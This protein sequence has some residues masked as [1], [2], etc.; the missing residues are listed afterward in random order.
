MIVNL[1]K[2]EKMFSLCLPEKVKGK[3]WLEDCDKRGR[4]RRVISVEGAQ[5]EWVLKSNSLVSILDASGEGIFSARL[6]AMSFLNLKYLRGAESEEGEIAFLFSERVDES[7]SRFRKYILPASGQEMPFQIGREK[8]NHFFYNNRFVSGSHARLTYEGDGNWSIV[9]LNSTNGTYVNGS[10]IESCELRAGDSIYIMGLKLIVGYNFLAVNNPDNQ[11]TVV[12]ENL[13]EYCPQKVITSGEAAPEASGRE[14]FFRS[15]RFHREIAPRKITIDPP[16]QPQKP[17]TVPMALMLGP[18]MTMGFTSLSTGLLTVNN[19]LRSGGNIAQAMPSV[20]MSFSMLL[21]TVLWPVLTR[22]YERRQRAGSERRRQQKYLAYLD[23]LRDEIRRECKIQS[24]I[25]LENHVSP[26]ECA[27]RILGRSANLWERSAGQNDFLT[28]RLGL[29]RLPLK[30]EITC[31]EKKFTMEEDNLQDAMLALG[32]EPKSV[33][34]VPV[35]ISLTENPVVGIYGKSQDTAAMLKSIILQMAAL[36]SSDELKLMMIADAGDGRE[37]EF[38]RFLPHLWNEERTFRFYAAAVEEVRELSSC[39]EKVIRER[40]DSRTPILPGPWI[41]VVVTDKVLAEKCEALQKLLQGRGNCGIS[42]VIA[43]E[44]LREL[45]GESKLVIHAAGQK[46]RV[47]DRSG[48]AEGVLHFRADSMNNLS[49]PMLA[50]ALAGI[51]PDVSVQH[52]ALPEQI[53]FLELFQVGK[54]EHLNSLTRWK[55]NNPV[56]TLQTPVGV[57]AAGEPFFLDLHER[58]HGPHG[59]VAGMTG[60]GKSEFIITYILSLAVNYHPDEVAFILIDYKGGGL[61]GAFEDESKGVRL[62]HLAGTITNLDGAAVKRSLVSIQS[63]LRRRQ[64]IFNGAK[65][66]SNAGTMDIYRYQQ[67]YRQGVV[68]EPVPHLFIISDEFAELKKQQSEFMEQL[69]SAARIGRSLGVHLILATQKPNGIVDDQIWS[70]SRFRVCLKVQEREDSNDMIKCPDAAELSQTGRFYFQVG[71]NEL[72]A[73]GQSAWCGAEYIPRDNLEETRDTGIQVIDR[74]G[75]VVISG[76]AGR[77]QTEEGGIRQVVGIVK[78]LSDLA[79]EEGIRERP[80]W[81]PPI[82]ALIYVDQLEE[83]YGRSSEGIVLNPTVGEYDDPAHQRKEALTVPFSE[84]G[85]CLVYGSPGNGKAL[86]LTTLC[87]ALIRNHTAAEVNL[88]LMDFGAGTLKVFEKAPQTGGVVTN[89]EEEKLVNLFRLLQ[90][91]LEERRNLFA[92]YGGDYAGYCRN[93]GRILPNIV[94][95]LNNYSGFAEQYEEL[96]DVLIQLTREGIRYGIYFVIT[97]DSVNAMRY[98]IV[99]NFKT[100]LTMQLND[101]SDYSVAVGRTEGLVPFRYPGRG[102]AALDRVYEFQTA[103]CREG[104]EDMDYLAQFCGELAENSVVFA[105]RIQVLPKTVTAEYVITDQMSLRNIPVGVEKDSLQIAFANLQDRMVFPVAA[106][107]LWQTKAFLT[108]LVKVLRQITRVMV[109]DAEGILSG[110]PAEE[111]VPGGEYEDFVKQLFENMVIRN[112][113]YVDAKHDRSILAAYEEMQIIVVGVKKL[114]DNLTEG[115]KDK[116]NTLL[117]HGEAF[118]GL[119]FVLADSAENIRGLSFNA[120]YKKHV[121][122]TEGLWIGDGV[123]DQYVLKCNKVT[124]LLYEEIGDGFGYLFNHGRP[125]RIKLLSEEVDYG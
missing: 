69:I 23:Q 26:E 18:S 125:V 45:P 37:W 8:G 104:A 46:S 108:E 52:Y 113:R 106:Q 24:D 34:D 29:G 64:V 39:L 102:L 12:S 25:L 111:L 123:A 107:E 101:A 33:E 13:L 54:I 116:W 81:L 57:D 68:T 5:G 38:V 124:A 75:R 96:Q 19:V 85:N 36:H 7:R 59:L 92:E 2:K 16:P 4:N 91:R 86:F 95:V 3:Y 100:V 118:Y 65:R 105:D 61:A 70:N 49:L 73:L 87:Y 82:P 42:V 74:L 47:Y 14:A 79:A 60:S 89:D 10:R 53:T 121:K 115:E 99:Q 80:L 27:S 78:Y 9:D 67:L 21:G 76:Q 97:A 11:L 15:P 28:V 114:F 110:V 1:I 117:E 31:P 103:H 112:N 62:P 22:K 71:F 58:F 35:C 94:V 83:K 40:T 63:E 17:D 98:K 6:T 50:E 72:F 41:V 56:K 43:A 93:S 55:E 120:W 66:M 122:G 48:T 44:E 90:D 84:E 119:R 32:T 51:R 77:R 20:L 30:A 88:H 109:V